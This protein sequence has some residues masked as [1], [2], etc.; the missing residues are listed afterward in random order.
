MS[1]KGKIVDDSLQSRFLNENIEMKIYLPENHSPLYTYQL[2]LAQ[3]GDDYLKKGKLPS[4]TS[5]LIEKGQIKNVII[6]MLPYQSIEDRYQK[7]H[8]NGAKNKN[9]IRFLAEE[10]VPYLDSTYHTF[11]LSSGRTLLGDSLAATV[12]VHAALEYPHTFGQV[13]AQSPYIHTST[14]D[15]LKAFKETELLKLYHVVGN[16]ESKVEL[17]KGKIKDFLT[18]NREFQKLAKQKGIDCFYDEFNGEHNWAYW[19][20]D[21][22]RAL[23]SMLS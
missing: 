16:K 23:L 17:S 10:L 8:P 7:Y 18:P 9:Y 12:N 5:E 6:V 14:L 4:L 2:L 19:Q 1:F 13:I 21:L 20:K 22:Q 11:Q 15:L 3:D